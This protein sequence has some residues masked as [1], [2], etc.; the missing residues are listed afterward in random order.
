M[1]APQE[2]IV[3]KDC[4]LHPLQRRHNCAERAFHGSPWPRAVALL[5]LRSL[6]VLGRGGQRLPSRGA[7]TGARV[8]L[9]SCRHWHHRDTF[10]LQPRGQARRHLGP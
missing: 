9:I 6:D 7:I 10:S 4:S 5:G 3:L 2:G 1:H 8:Q